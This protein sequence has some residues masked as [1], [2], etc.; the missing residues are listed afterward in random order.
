MAQHASVADLKAVLP[1]TLTKSQEKVLGEIL[2]DFT[3]P[4]PM[5]RLLQVG[6]GPTKAYTPPSN[7]P[8]H[9]F[10]QVPMLNLTSRPVCLWYSIGFSSVPVFSF[11]TLSSRLHL[12]SIIHSDKVCKTEY[13]L[14][15]D[16]GCGKTVIAFL[17]ML[18][19]TGSGFQAALMA[20]TE[21][22]CYSLHDQTALLHTLR[23]P[24]LS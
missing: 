20:P 3:E 12:L 5:F 13:N 6:S 18:A 23:C 17:A 10:K 2:Y 7:E 21:V 8:H 4:L 11:I 19:A 22:Q 14:Q 15:G 16:V 9:T 1:Y 24:F